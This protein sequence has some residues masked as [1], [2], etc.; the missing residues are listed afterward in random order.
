MCTKQMVYLIGQKFGG[1]NCRKFGLMP[2]F[3]S[4]EKFCPPKIL[5][6]EIFC[7]PNFC[8]Y[9]NLQV[10]FL[11]S[12]QKLTQK[13]GNVILVCNLC[14]T[15]MLAVQ[16]YVRFGKYLKV[17]HVLT[18]FSVWVVFFL[19]I[20]ENIV[21]H[22]LC[23]NMLL[24]KNSADKNFRRT[25]LPKFRVGAESFVRRIILSAENFVRRI[26]VR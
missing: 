23:V 3:L 24:D 14:I 21:K 5:S 26:F 19:D 4:A 20:F 18:F 17:S 11:C 16:I 2:K 10:V 9:V 22:E 8:P 13:F 25:K 1:Q 12:F 7:P 15:D 6:A